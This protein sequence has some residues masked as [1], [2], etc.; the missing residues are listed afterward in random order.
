MK[1]EKRQRESPAAKRKNGNSA[2]FTHFWL[3]RSLK[4]V[5]SVGGETRWKPR[6]PA[7]GIGVLWLERKTL[8]HEVAGPFF[9]IW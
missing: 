8:I 9:S 2:N 6:A 5:P 7:L 4:N 1:N 3:T